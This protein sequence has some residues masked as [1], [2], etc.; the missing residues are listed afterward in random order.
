LRKR[1]F[2]IVYSF[3]FSIFLW[4]SVTLNFTYS[5]NLTIPLEVKLRENQALAEDLQNEIDIVA[6]GRGWDLLGMW[7]SKTNVFYLDLSSVRK[8]LKYSILQAIGDKI[9]LPSDVSIISV[10][11]DTLNIEFDNISTKF[12][13]IK[14]NVTISLKDGYEIIGSPDMMPDSVKITGASSVL[15][16]IKYFPTE[17]KVFRNVNSD[18][19]FDVSLSDT[20][21][22]LIKIEP[23]SIK[24][25]YKVELAAEKLFEDLNITVK[26][27]PADKD[28]LLIPPNIN[29]SI[30]GGVDILSKVTPSDIK[31]TIDYDLIDKDT[32]GSV[33]PNIEIPDFLT[34]IN[35]TPQKFQYII[36]KKN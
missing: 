33:I 25:F 31:I 29:L 19:T 32:L 30:R 36:K 23:K 1:I 13:N 24:I 26:N 3:L 20:L 2:L 21:N 11:P 12:V 6:R 4:L 35:S 27:V 34:L 8:N 9:N 15:S 10:N 16:K 14:N 22:S 18:V 28:V 5:I 17:R 7:F